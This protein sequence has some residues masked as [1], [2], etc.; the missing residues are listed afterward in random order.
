MPETAESRDGEIAFQGID[1]TLTKARLFA[2]ALKYS[3]YADLTTEKN[4][5][6]VKLVSIVSQILQSVSRLPIP[7]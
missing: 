1:V 2:D 5:N 7:N 3:G 4:A 6:G